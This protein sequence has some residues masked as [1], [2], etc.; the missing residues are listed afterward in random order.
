MSLLD[1]PSFVRWLADGFRPAVRLLA[2]AAMP[3]VRGRVAVRGLSGPVEVLRDRWG[4]PH[5]YGRDSLDLFH[6]QG[7]VH[8]QDRMFQM[9]LARRVAGGRLSEAFGEVALGTDRLART[10]GFRRVA[11]AEWAAYEEGMRATLTAYARGVNAFLEA[12]QGR[13]GAEYRVLGLEPEPF[14]AVDCLTFGKFQAWH[15]SHSW[16]A[17]I[18]RARLV[19]AVGAEAAA[20]LEPRHPSSQPCILEAGVAAETLSLSPGVRAG[21]ASPFSLPPHEGGVGSNSWAVAPGRSATGGAILANDMHLEL[22]LP[23][24]WY[25]CHMV[26]ADGSYNVSG[27]SI[28]GMPGLLVGHNDRIAWGATLG[29]CD[30]QDLYLE[31]L[32]WDGVPEYQFEGAWRPATVHREEI[33]IKGRAAP[34]VEN[35]VETGHGPV[36]GSCLPG[37][38]VTGAGEALS[39]CSVALRPGRTAA[40]FLA[41]N[42]ARGWDE[43]TKGVRSIAA[44]DINVTYADVDGNVGYHLSGQIPIRERGDGRVP[45]PGWSGDH[46]WVGMI[47]P[48]RMPQ[49]LNPPRGFVVTANNRVADSTYPYHLGSSFMNGYRAA[50]ITSRLHVLERV[51]LDDCRELQMDL[52]SLAAGELIARLEGFEPGTQEGRLALG[53]LRGWDR[54]MAPESAGAAVF[55][56]L[57]ARLVRNLLAPLAE[58]LRLEVLGQGANPV[59][60]PLTEFMGKATETLH[61]LLDHPGSHWIREVGG[62][63]ALIER[64]LGETVAA[65]RARQGTDPARWQWGRMHRVYFQHAFTRNPV[66]ALFFDRGPHPVGGDTDTV[67]QTA[68]LPDQPYDNLTYSPSYRQIVD[69]GNLDDSRVIIP[70]G[71]SGHLGSPH[72][73]DMIEPWLAGRFIPMLWSRAAVERETVERMSLV[74]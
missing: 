39:L 25:L 7:F 71:Q 70:A 1:A 58:T 32:R 28:P 48:E 4:V 68:Y 63:A 45:V 42:R 6:A 73:D 59:L 10:L 47:P 2:G 35:V 29:F 9:D 53:L 11:E 31:R 17:E 56:V 66:L 13:L 44:P 34:H 49:V 5:L 20:E 67:H 33:R 46:E 51:T 22:K 41:I 61:A 12:A 15:L 24:I 37:G 21:L 72:Y 23:G 40:G 18:T 74:P 14:T 27:A 8:A 19:Q 43:F 36:V 54:Q 30:Q 52:H 60:C 64:S 65:L 16:L 50:R 55:A 62:R 38:A 57:Q 26:A 69:L 3:R